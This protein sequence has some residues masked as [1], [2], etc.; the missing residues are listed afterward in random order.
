MLVLAYRH[1]EGM[2]L[3]A[4]GQELKNG[5]TGEWGVTKERVRQIEHQGF[6]KLRRKPIPREE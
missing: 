2:T 5:H 1:Y 4:V 3:A 6:R